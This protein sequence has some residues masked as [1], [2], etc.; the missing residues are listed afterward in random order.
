MLLPRLRLR[1]PRA[2]LSLHQKSCES[3][4]HSSR[5][6]LRESVPP[7]L[8]SSQTLQAILRNIKS[9][10]LSLPQFSLAPREKFHPARRHRESPSPVPSL[11]P[12]ASP[13]PDPKHRPKKLQALVLALRLDLSAAPAN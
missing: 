6:F 11:I 12:K 9:C 8:P 7:A 2:L 1:C 13:Q 4:L 3:A 10:R 5:R